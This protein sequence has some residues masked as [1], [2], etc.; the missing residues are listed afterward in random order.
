MGLFC[1]SQLRLEFFLVNFV[2]SFGTCTKLL[3]STG[4]VFCLFVLFIGVYNAMT[5]T[6]FN[7]S[8]WWWFKLVLCTICC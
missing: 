4:F 3:T 8:K 5:I 7:L 6:C 1:S 2:W